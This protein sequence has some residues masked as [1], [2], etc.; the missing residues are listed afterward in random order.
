M[1]KTSTRG[2]ATV[3]ANPGRR[4]VA[5]TLIGLAL[6]WS[7]AS[8]SFRLEAGTP[9]PR[10]PPPG[11]YILDPPHTFI[12]FA[13]QHK[14]VG[15]VRG[16]FD[17]MTGTFTAAKDPA[18]C[19]VEVTIETPSVSTQNTIRDE[20]LRSASFFDAAKF[21]AMTYRGTGIR[22]SGKGWVMDGALTIRGVTRTVPLSFEFRGLAPRQA[23]ASERVA[24]HATAS[25]KRADFEMTRELLDEIGRVTKDPDVWIEID[26]EALSAVPTK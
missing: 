22:R 21:L 14:V 23:G 17:R 18:A 12:T 26:A 11:A 24:F 8:N 15:I 5:C 20:D 4:R 6:L 7:L 13:A 16:R 2:F 3:P 25:V 1:T 10:L 9:A 19:A